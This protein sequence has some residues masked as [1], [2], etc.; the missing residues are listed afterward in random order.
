MEQELLTRADALGLLMELIEDEVSRDDFDKWFEQI[1]AFLRTLSSEGEDAEL[2][3][4]LIDLLD[5]LED[6]RSEL[7]FAEKEKVWQ[8]SLKEKEAVIE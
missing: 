4:L 1:Q 7:D 5:S 2:D 8:A 6:K 3:G